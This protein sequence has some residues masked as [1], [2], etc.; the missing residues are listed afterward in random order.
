MK[1][2]DTNCWTQALRRKGEPTVR[3]RV[4]E[5]LNKGEAAWCQ[6]IRLELWRGANNDWDKELLEH[7]E[8][9]VK[10]LAI[11]MQVW[12]RSVYFSQQLRA[13]GITVPLPDLVIFACACVHDVA[14]EHHDKHFELLNNKFPTG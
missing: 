10:M 4:A 5:L 13:E 7:L 8:S 2:I 9:Q 12:D 3:A 6:L 1:L 11:S 14:V